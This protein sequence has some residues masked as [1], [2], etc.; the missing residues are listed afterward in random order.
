M[1]DQ[2]RY[3][4]LC[5]HC[6]HPQWLRFERLRWDKGQPETAA[7]VCESCGTAIAEH[8]KTWML[9]RGEWRAMAQDANPKTAGFHLS[10]L[11]SSVGWCVWC[12]IAA[13]WEAAVNKESGSAAAIKTFKNTELGKTWV[14][15]GE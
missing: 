11:Y 15:E 13:A 8:H 5:P 12:D 2:R 10:S 9:E 3:F 4:V 1:F 14:E 6:K 7:Y